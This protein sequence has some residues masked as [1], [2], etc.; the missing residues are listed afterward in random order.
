MAIIQKPSISQK[1]KGT[2]HL[3]TAADRFE[4]SPLLV[5]N[6]ATDSFRK[7]KLEKRKSAHSETL[8]FQKIQPQRAKPEKSFSDA[9]EAL[10]NVLS[11]LDLTTQ[12]LKKL[13]VSLKKVESFML[14]AKNAPTEDSFHS[15]LDLISDEMDRYDHDLKNATHGGMNLLSQKNQRLLIKLKGQEERH[16]EIRTYMLLSASSKMESSTDMSQKPL[17]FS[18]EILENINFSRA[19]ETDSLSS[20]I[21]SA[22]DI[23]APIHTQLQQ[24]QGYFQE[25]TQELGEFTHSSG[26]GL[27]DSPETQRDLPLEQATLLALNAKQKLSIQGGMQ[28]F[29]S[30]SDLSLLTF[31]SDL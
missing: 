12:Q 22:V 7:E 13:T 14:V 6:Q 29:I 17:R 20:Q 25:K 16:I 4:K 24:A 30:N 31:F 8:S 2:L 28:G 27:T 15:Q 1:Y 19:L 11:L 3:P 21:Q 9:K 26:K 10:S 23:L 5:N 18:L